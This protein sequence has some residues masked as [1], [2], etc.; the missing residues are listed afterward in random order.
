MPAMKV[1]RECPFC[2]HGELT[3][4]VV[5]VEPRVLAVH[6]LSCERCASSV[7]EFHRRYRETGADA[8]LLSALLL[9]VLSA[10]TVPANATLISPGTYTFNVDF[11]AELPYDFAGVLVQGTGLDAGEVVGV[12]VCADIN[13]GGGCSAQGEIGPA[14][15]SSAPRLALLLFRAHRMAYSRCNSR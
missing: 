8:R 14:P 9:C 6:W 15:L 11:T 7:S 4:I 10:H 3:V 12:A 5:K 2:A 1:M 13:G